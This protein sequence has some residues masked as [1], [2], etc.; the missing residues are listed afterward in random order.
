MRLAELSE[1]PAFLEQLLTLVPQQGGPMLTLL[2]TTLKNYLM[3]RYNAP[4]RPIGGDQKALLRGSLLALYYQ[5]NHSPQAV[6]LYQDIVY[7]VLAVDFPWP[8]V[9][10]ALADDLTGPIAA[11]IYFSR[12]VVK[13]NEW[14]Q[15]DERRPLEVFLTQFMPQIEG[16][17]EQVLANYN[18]ETAKLLEQILKTFY[19]AFHIEVP[20]YLRDFNRLAKW[21]GY[22]ETI[23]LCPLSITPAARLIVA[24][25]YLKFFALYANEVQDGRQFRGWAEEFRR[26]FAGRLLGTVMQLVVAR[27]GGDDFLATL[28]N[29]L[30]EVVKQDRLRELVGE[31]DWGQLVYGGVLLPLCQPSAEERSLFINDPIEYVRR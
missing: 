12:Q 24:R 20:L 5:L 2:L 31:Q 15:G 6:N 28:V 21:V 29:C 3:A 18:D 19:S 25:S 1:H 22:F 23:L 27:G 11:G 4:D 17:L 14:F 13:V 30:H 9:E 26:V 7:M 10:H 16:V 8:G